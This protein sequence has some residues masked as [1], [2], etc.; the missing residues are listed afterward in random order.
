MSQQA[1][2]ETTSLYESEPKIYP[3][4]ARGRYARLRVLAMVVLLGLYY[5]LPWITIG[6]EPIVH[7]DLPARR[8]HVFGLTLVPQ[9]L[10]LLSWL[11]ILA[12]LTLFLFTTLGGR[13]WC[14]YAC[15]QTVWTES[16]L[17][18]E[19]WIEGER[20]QRI[21]LDQAP[22]GPKKIL[23][24]GGK[25]LAWIVFAAITGITFVAYFVPMKELIADIARF[26]MGGWA[27]FWSAFY[28]FATWG[29]AGFM[30]EQVCKYMCPYARFQSAMFDKDTLIIAYDEKRGEP[31]KRLAKREGNVAGDCIDC[32][33]CV[34]VCPT[35]I[36]I[37][38]GLQYE[39]IACAACVDACNS[40]M[41][42]VGKPRGLIR[43]TSERHDA[44]GRFHILR[45]RMI[46]Y[47]VVWLVIG[48]ALVTAL[49]MR[50]PV[51]LDV[52]RDRNNLYRELPGGI[53]ENVFVLR[54][55]NKREAPRS[56]AL[57]A[58]RPDGSVLDLHPERVT[59][60][61]SE[62]RPLTVGARMPAD[63]ADRPF[64]I[65]FTATA[66]DDPGIS[67]RQTGR[68]IPGALP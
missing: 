64:D 58:T 6:G 49:V 14:G 29:N 34:Q 33:L 30:R 39:C 23:R 24:K 41:D 48:A 36:D 9:D 17:W 43:Y 52:M 28:G 54:L 12:A 16:F 38:D 7:F 53:I 46:G 4:M 10:F 47:F 18:I 32:S 44:E 60:E 63:A 19:R 50:S 57:Q 45:P 8:F 67:T 37:R 20:H 26:E 1:Q 11:L 3:R 2:T 21:K 68:F 61:G 51:E 59:L 65:T 31:R 22:W 25:H 13:L 55:T 62:T 27:L 56:F 35:G 42:H 5:L 40:I 15:P 66:T